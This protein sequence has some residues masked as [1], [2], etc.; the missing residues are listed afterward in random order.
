V[1]LLRDNI[2]TI[3]KKQ[4]SCNCYNKEVSP[5]INI[6]KTKFMLVSFSQNAGQIWDIKISDCLK[7]WHSLNILE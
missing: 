3:Q 4:I 2:D 1:N 6:E 7:M 5:E